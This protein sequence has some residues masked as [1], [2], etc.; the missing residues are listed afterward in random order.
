[1]DTVTKTRLVDALQRQHDFY[2]NRCLDRRPK[3][4]DSARW[5]R[6]SGQQ[7]WETQRV[8]VR[9]QISEAGSTHWYCLF[10]SRS[11]RDS[12]GIFLYYSQEVPKGSEQSPFD[13]SE[14]WYY[15]CQSS[16][17]P[18]SSL[19]IYPASEAPTGV[20]G[21]AAGEHRWG[22][23]SD[24]PRAG[25]RRARNRVKYGTGTTAPT[26]LSDRWGVPKSHRLWG[27][28]PATRNP[29]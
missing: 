3:P 25:E 20:G 28:C 19:S 22:R 17:Y 16:L 2:V 24:A 11:L 15:T 7:E 6:L 23:A 10:W 8:R 12:F 18:Q 9:N 27:S 29:L 14:I 26:S 21:G 13:D 4:G 5:R 1:M